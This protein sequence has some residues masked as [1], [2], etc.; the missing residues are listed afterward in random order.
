[1]ALIDEIKAQYPDPHM[2]STPFT[3]DDDYCVGGAVCRYAGSFWYFPPNS[4]LARVLTKLNPTLPYELAY[5]YA[6]LIT[7]N[8]DLGRFA[9]AWNIAD[10]ALTYEVATDI[11]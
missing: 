1:M 8:N 7:E 4:A 9:E 5:Q 10:S 11:V 3:L 2:S 6:K